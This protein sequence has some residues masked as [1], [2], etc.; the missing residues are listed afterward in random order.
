MIIPQP[1]EGEEYRPIINCESYF[2]SNFGHVWSGKSGRRL[3]MRPTNRGYLNTGITVNGKTKMMSAHRLVATAFIPNPDNKPQVNHKD[4]DKQNNNVSNL[5]WVTDQ[6]N[7][8]HARMIV[9][10]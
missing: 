8:D 3:G 4:K 6:E 2:I 5:E 10:A 1:E 7:K 9:I